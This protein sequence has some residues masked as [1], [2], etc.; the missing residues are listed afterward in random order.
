MGVGDTPSASAVNGAKA[1][2][3]ATDAAKENAR[4]HAGG[5]G[6]L[7]GAEGTRAREHADVRLSE[8]IEERRRGM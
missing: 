6:A 7:I 2:P 8:T 4:S 5:R 3:Q 1:P